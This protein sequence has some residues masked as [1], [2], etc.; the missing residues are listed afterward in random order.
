MRCVIETCLS[1]YTHIQFLSSLYMVLL[2]FIL[3]VTW[4]FSGVGYNML[5]R[6]YC[7]LSIS[8][9]DFAAKHYSKNSCF[10]LFKIITNSEF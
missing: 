8:L 6:Q 9:F 10:K 7:R 4:L 1:L 3:I 5:V 2:S